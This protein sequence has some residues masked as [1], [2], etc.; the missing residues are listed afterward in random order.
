[1]LL[2][3]LLLVPLGSIYK[4]LMLEGNIRE[5]GSGV[6]ENKWGDAFAEKKRKKK[7]KINETH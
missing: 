3:L 7:R 2:L 1:M 6:G 5:N 4:S